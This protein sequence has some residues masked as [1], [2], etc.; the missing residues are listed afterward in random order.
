MTSRPEPRG[1][2]PEGSAAS[3]RDR[4]LLASRSARRLEQLGGFLL[5]LAGAALV[6]LG[7]WRADKPA[8]APLL[9]VF[10]AGMI[11]LGAFYSRIEGNIEATKDG[12]K[13]VVREV[14]RVAVASDLSSDEFAVLLSLALERLEAK[15]VRPSEVLEAARVA[16]DEAAADPDASPIELERRLA[17]DVRRWLETENWEVPDYPIPGPDRGY[18]M[19]AT[20]EGTRLLIELRLARYRPVSADLVERAAL[21]RE[22]SA[23]HA[24][25]TRMAIVMGPQSLA[26]TQAA[27]DSARERGVEIDRL[28]RGAKSRSSSALCAERRRASCGRAS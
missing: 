3:R 1:A 20:K 7:I 22:L 21:T 13:A 8:V 19:L 14:E 10:G 12:I 6:G 23:S 18:D 28:S 25:D 4:D 2:P 5:L 16:A 26:P 24:S 27:R 15:A 17:S 11:L 9:I